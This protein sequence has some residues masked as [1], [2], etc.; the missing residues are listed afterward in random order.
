MNVHIQIRGV[1]I[2]VITA[3]R[4]WA[5]SVVI[6][7]DL[8]MVANYLLL[9]QSRPCLS[10]QHTCNPLTAR[11]VQKHFAAKISSMKSAPAEKIRHQLRKFHKGHIIR[12]PF[13]PY[14]FSSLP[15][16]VVVFRHLI[17]TRRFFKARKLCTDHSRFNDMMSM[18]VANQL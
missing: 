16:W 8:L 1:E 2:S 13:I 15:R 12:H 18:V 5:L 7:S 9:D 17:F 6:A 3:K 4:S 14:P 11:F 10:V